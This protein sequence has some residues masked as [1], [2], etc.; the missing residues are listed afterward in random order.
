MSLSEVQ[1]LF[2]APEEAGF[3]TRTLAAPGTATE[4]PAPIEPEEAPVDNTPKPR[5]R[6]RRVLL[7]ALLTLLAVAAGGTWWALQ[8]P[9][10]A[11]GATA[12]T[13]TPSASVP[14]SPAATPSTPV[15]SAS[16]SVAPTVT[17]AKPADT[18]TRKPNVTLRSEMA[19]GFNSAT[20]SPKA[21]QAID[22]VAQQV[23]SAGLTGKIYIDGYTDNLGSEA[24]GLVL[25]QRRADAVAHYLGSQLVGVPVSIVSTGH[26]EKNPVADNSTSQGRKANRRV[27][28]TLP[29]S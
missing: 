26:G 14:A 2:I 3:T 19:F 6:V 1:S 5:R 24:Y 17:H 22:Q 15:T 25:S 20:L 12:P 10:S 28:I 13:P 29:T 16:S 8:G 27:T 18:P 9:G 4:P 7:S 23:R 21:K 11:S